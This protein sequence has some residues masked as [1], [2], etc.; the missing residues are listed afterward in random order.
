MA[1]RGYIDEIRLRDGKV[2]LR[3]YKSMKP[4]RMKEEKVDHDPQLTLY[5]VAVC[6]LSRADP[7]FA[8]SL[9]LEDIAHTFMGNPAFTSDRVHPEFFVLDSL[10]PQKDPGQTPHQVVFPSARNDAHFHALRR[11]IEITKNAVA[12]GQIVYEPGVKC[13]FCPLKTPCLKL[14]DQVANELPQNPPKQLIFNF[15]AQ[16]FMYRP[17]PIKKPKV[18]QKRFHW[19]KPK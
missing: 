7:D 12:S 6:A 3:D 19:K 15:A 1:F 16:S 18:S 14:Y 11:M 5:N 4:E 17:P 2:I 9:G 13:G 8:R 10:I